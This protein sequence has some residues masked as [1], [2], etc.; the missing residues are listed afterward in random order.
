MTP[1]VSYLYSLGLLKWWTNLCLRPGN[2]C[3][4][5]D[6]ENCLWNIFCCI[7]FSLVNYEEF[8][9]F[10]LN[11]SE[12]CNRIPIYLLMRFL[13][14]L[15]VNFILVHSLFL[16]YGYFLFNL[17]NDWNHLNGWN[18]CNLLLITWIKIELLL[19]KSIF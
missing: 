13:F 12:N 19:N 17:N 5:M 14:C 4:F 6:L 18:I 11:S 3:V 10:L 7:H 15:I 1:S 8:A 9:T 16:Y 2:R